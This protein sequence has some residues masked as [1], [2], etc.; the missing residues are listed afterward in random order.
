[1]QFPLGLFVVHSGQDRYPIA[2]KIEAIGLR[3]MAAE[4]SVQL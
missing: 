2:D 1:M 4:L 3:A